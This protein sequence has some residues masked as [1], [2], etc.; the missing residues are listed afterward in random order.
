MTTLTKAAAQWPLSAVFIFDIGATGGSDAMVNTSGV[1]T[2]FKAASGTVYDIATLPPQSFLTD[3]EVDVVT[4][5]DDTGTAT[6]TVGDA[7]SANRYLGATTIKTVA[8]TALVPTGLFLTAATNLRIT[9]ANANGNA[10][11][12]KVIV[13]ANIVIVGRVNENLKMV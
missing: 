10:T 7:S 5:S 12:G 3:G 11:V 8:R 4:A 6:I 13:R 1:L 9:L 2:S